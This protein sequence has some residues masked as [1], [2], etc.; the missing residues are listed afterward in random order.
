MMNV[1]KLNAFKEQN[2]ALMHK[3]IKSNSVKMS[4]CARQV[5]PSN[6]KMTL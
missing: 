2:T 3:N 4:T 6:K 5:D 1:K